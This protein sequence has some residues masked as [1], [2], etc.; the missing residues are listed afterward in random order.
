[1]IAMITAVVVMLA[2]TLLISLTE[3]M[4]KAHQKRLLDA[5][6]ALSETSAADGLAYLLETEGS[7]AAAGTVSFELAGVATEFSLAETGSAGIRRGYYSLDDPSG[8]DYRIP[9]Q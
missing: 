7:G 1:M 8:T 4:V 6:I 9:I 3:R 5:Q 2:A